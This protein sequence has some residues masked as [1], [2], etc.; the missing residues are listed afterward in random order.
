[1]RLVASAASTT[2]EA[3]PG[4]PEQWEGLSARLIDENPF[5]RDL[6]MGPMAFILSSYWLSQ[7]LYVLAKLKVYDILAVRAMTV[8]EIAAAVDAD[9]TS[10]Y[11]VLRA[12]AG[13]GPIP[14]VV[15]E[16][17]PPPDLPFELPFNLALPVPPLPFGLSHTAGLDDLDRR[18]ALTPLGALLRSD[19][20]GG[21]YPW[22]IMSGEEMFGA[23]GS[24]L[25]G[26]K[27]GKVP[28]ELST[29]GSNLWEFY[30]E[31]PDKSVVFD[32]AMASFSETNRSLGG[33][34]GVRRD[35]M[36]PLRTASATASS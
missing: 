24:L 12:L 14:G 4:E 28:F 23:W 35:V 19:M 10:L 2:T 22:A 9:P 27:T 16:V 21:I 6:L 20:E 1:M 17:F 34:I 25:E 8:R 26:V 13:Q 36:R 5:L 31:R 33:V 29:G 7:C 3:S 18:Y 32:R 11:R 15:I 30:N